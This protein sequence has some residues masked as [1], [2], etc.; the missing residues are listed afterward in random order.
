M[1]EIDKL[2]DTMYLDDMGGYIMNNDEKYT[3]TT[4]L[5]DGTSEVVEVL[6]SFKFNDNNQEYII[7]T[8]NEVDE[9]GNVTLYVSNVNRNG[10]DITLT[11]VS[12]DNEWARIKDVLRELSKNE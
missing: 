11:T 12:D 3:M 1:L 4:V 10:N 9:N 8:K 6:L 5:A 2:Y 7:Y